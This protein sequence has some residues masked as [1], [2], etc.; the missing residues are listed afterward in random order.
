[1]VHLPKIFWR[2]G[3]VAEINLFR[4]KNFRE[5]SATI[6]KVGQ[7]SFR[8]P[9]FY[10]PVRLCC[11]W[12]LNQHF[13]YLISLQMGGGG[14]HVARVTYWQWVILQQWVTYCKGLNE[15]LT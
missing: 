15:G 6:R 1:M 2:G 13:F 5:W 4:K 14:A 3:E 10:L 8:P 11:Q 12:Q 9:N 7:I